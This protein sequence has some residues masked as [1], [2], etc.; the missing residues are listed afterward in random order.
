MEKDGSIF[1]GFVSTD[2][3]LVDPLAVNGVAGATET[4][5]NLYDK[6]GKILNDNVLQPTQDLLPE[7]GYWEQTQIKDVYQTVEYGSAAWCA[8]MT[9]HAQSL[10]ST[11]EL[12][13]SRLDLLENKTV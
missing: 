1:Q 12:L 11:I 3:E 4:L 8:N 2:Y 7:G 10:Q 6:D 9:A 5:G 13:V